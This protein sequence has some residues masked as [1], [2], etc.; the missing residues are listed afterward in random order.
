MK[1]NF[2]IKSFIC[3]ISIIQHTYL[4]CLQVNPQLGDNLWHL[5]AAI[6]TVI[7][8]LALEQTSC[9][10]KIDR[11]IE[12]TTDQCDLA[13]TFSSIASTIQSKIDECCACNHT[14]IFQATTITTAGTY[15]LANNI[16]GSIVISADQ[17]V[18]DLNQH[19]ITNNGSTA[20]TIS[21]NFNGTTIQ[22]GYINA[23]TTGINAS[24]GNSG[25]SIHNIYMDNIANGISITSAAQVTIHNV[26]ILCTS[27]T[28][29]GIKL[30]S[31]NNINIQDSNVL[32]IVGGQMYTFDTC[33]SANLINCFAKTTN[34]PIST[35]GFNIVNCLGMNLQSCNVISDP[36]ATTVIGFSINGSA[37]ANQSAYLANCIALSCSNIGFNTSDG[38]DTQ[39]Y[40]L[41]NCSA[42][43]SNSN[44]SLG[45]SN[46]LLTDCNAIGGTTGYIITTTGTMTNCQASMCTQNGFQ[47]SSASN[48][49]IKSCNSSNNSGNGFLFSTIL[50]SAKNVIENCTA[51]SNTGFGLVGTGDGN[52]IFYE[53][54][55]SGNTAGNYSNVVASPSANIQLFTDPIIS[56]VDNV[57]STNP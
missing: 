21:S 2:K 33:N 37:I 6:G 41:E 53:N 47:G 35:V 44:F 52:A 5:T 10:S 51:T 27:T 56:R 12:R 34:T 7:D 25:I 36:T 16:S 14:P 20:I 9:C 15:C 50:S 8:E 11:L 43:Q 24:L 49:L 57:R 30:T 32:S 54:Q 1:L 31:T 48:W 4:F 46:G 39:T 55:A 19:T 42:L 3:L 40:V 23:A 18:L 22:N 38:D 13:N 17:A 29:T 26:D 28:G 45:R